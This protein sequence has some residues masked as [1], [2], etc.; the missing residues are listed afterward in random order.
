VKELEGLSFFKDLLEIP[1]NQLV[2]KALEQGKTAIGYNCYLVPEALISAGNVFPVWM[3]APGVEST[4][5]SDYCLSSVVCSYA[6][7][8]LQAGLDGSYDFLGAL[9]FAPTCDHIR[10]GGQHFDL[11]GINAD[12]ENFFVYMLDT[13]NKVN[14]AGMKWLIKDIKKLVVKLNEA[15]NANINE[16]TIKKAIKDLNEFNRLMKSIGDMRK[17]AN[18]KITGTEFH[19]IYGASK[20]APKD[21]LIEPL[22]KIKAELEARESVAS[23]KI[24]L[25]VVGPVFDNP[26]FTELIE[27]QGAVV[28]ADRYCFGSLPGMEPIEEEGDPYENMVKYQMETCQCARMMEKSKERVEYSKNLVKEYG[29]EG[30]IF[31]TMKFCDLWGYE[32][33]TFIDHMKESNIPTVKIEREYVL[34]GEGQFRTRIQAFLESIKSKK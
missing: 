22:K 17:G 27:A 23:D 31:E 33:L 34:A 25:M 11:Q 7:S 14:D 15:Y 16:E 20:V 21:M 10:R 12:K 18:P 32:G 19:I 13:S 30:V 3:R 8:V 24:R 1:Q 9:V 5:E 6:K 28:V 29:V 4:P 26:A 2:D